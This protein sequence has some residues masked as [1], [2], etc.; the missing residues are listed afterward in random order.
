M[1]PWWPA[2]SRRSSAL[3]LALPARK[4]SALAGLLAA[5]VYCLI[6]GFAVPA[7]RT[8]YMVGVVALALWAGRVSSVSRVL[9]AALLLVL[10]LDPWAGLA[11]GFWLSFGAVAVILYVATGRLRAGQAP[12]PGH[13]AALGHSL[14]QWGRV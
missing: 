11:P 3:M 5:L 6:A 1:S 2:C 14:V 9:C 7:Q 12:A 8:L 4:A 13:G 10:V